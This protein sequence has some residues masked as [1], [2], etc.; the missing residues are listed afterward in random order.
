MHLC[1]LISTPHMPALLLAMRRTKNKLKQLR[2]QL[3]L[4]KK[5]FALRR[6]SSVLS[7]GI[8]DDDPLTPV[9]VL[10][11]ACLFLHASLV[12]ACISCLFLHASLHLSRARFRFLYL[13]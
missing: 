9:R 4:E 13:S 12:P 1:R 6:P 5:R 11:Y 10:A 8:D 3:R 7:A 2:R